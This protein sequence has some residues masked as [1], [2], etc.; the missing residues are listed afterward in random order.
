MDL[1]CR[2]CGASRTSE[3]SKI[4]VIAIVDDDNSVREATRGLVRSLGYIAE[5]FPSAED[6]LQ[7]DRVR[8][9]ACL[10]TDV[11]MPGMSGVDLQDRLID[12][13]HHT[14]I[15]FMTAFPTES[16]RV[17]VAEGGAYGF[18][19]KP[20]DEQSLLDCLLKALSMDRP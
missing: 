8:E 20:Y 13:G 18:L 19:C 16:L 17:R 1:G 10:I 9:T 14:P 5:A 12:L 15:I 2:I 4:P 6:Y 11:Q 3:L 7:S